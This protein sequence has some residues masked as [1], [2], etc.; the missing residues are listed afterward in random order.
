MHASSLRLGLGLVLVMAVNGQDL[1]QRYPATLAYVEP[2]VGHATTTGPE[3]VWEL[4]DLEIDL[5]SK[6][7]VDL[8]RCD[9]VLGVHGADVLWAVAKPRGAAFLRSSLAGEGERI[10]SIW[11]R[12]H[13]SRVGRLFP[14][15][16]VEGPGQAKLVTEAQ[17]VQ[18]WKLRGSWQTNNLAVVPYQRSLVVDLETETSRHF[19]HAD[20]DAGTVAYEPSFARQPMPAATLLEEGAGAAAFDEVWRA[21]DREYPYFEIKDVDWPALRER[22][23]PVAANA[24]TAFEAAV[25]IGELLRPLQDPHVWVS[26]GEVFVPLHYRQRPLNGNYA[27]TLSQLA[28]TS[29][30]QAD[31]VYGQTEDGIGYIGVHRLMSQELP[32]AV[33]EALDALQDCHALIFDLRFNGGGGEGLAKE[34]TGRFLEDSVVYGAS[35]FRSGADHAAFGPILPRR[36]APRGPWTFRAPIVVLQGQRTMS[37]AEA[38]VLML[39]QVPGAV[40]MGDRTAGASANPRR[41]ELDGGIA[42]NLPRWKAL[43]AE[44]QPF[45]DVGLAPTI[46]LVPEPAAFHR[47]PDPLMAAAL[48]RLRALP[49]GERRPGRRD[50]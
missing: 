24:T 19:F 32:E 3:H 4:T 36:C 15:V 23:R 1:A 11:L 29:D 16:W 37:S 38:F 47:G 33:D 13:P 35:R 30:T 25:A 17:R 39:R 48:A 27:G 6:L 5:G 28:Q 7:R 2:A 9:V 14:R 41:I 8:G 40:T 18:S 50:E 21:F 26:A 44:S 49:E 42:V 20:L 43:D 12:F 46:E 34:I 10:E 31:L 22:W 45:E